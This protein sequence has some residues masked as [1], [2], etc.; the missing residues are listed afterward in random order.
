MF[1]FPICGHLLAELCSRTAEP[2][3]ACRGHLRCAASAATPSARRVKGRQCGAP[4]CEA[5]CLPWT[6]RAR[7]TAHAKAGP[8]PSEAGSRSEQLCVMRG[9]AVQRGG[10][11]PP[12]EA[13]TRVSLN[14]PAA[15][16]GPGRGPGPTRANQGAAAAREANG[17]AYEASKPSKP[18]QAPNRVAGRNGLPGRPLVAAPRSPRGCLSSRGRQ[19]RCGALAGAARSDPDA[20][21]P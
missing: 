1:S 8:S 15:W 4:G 16:L 18:G 3:C 2:P 12:T 7:S 9:S 5:H 20:V 13:S 14:A 21:W 10:A 17:R 19:W 6:L 11:R